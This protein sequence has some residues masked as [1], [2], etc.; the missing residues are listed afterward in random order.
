M[1]KI[2]VFTTHA[3]L[4]IE[5]AQLCIQQLS[6]SDNPETFDDFLVYNTHPNEL[7]N[8]T[9]LQILEEHKIQD[10]IAKNIK[11]ISSEDI[12]SRSLGS[13]LINIFT[14]C[15]ANYESTDRI[16]LLKSDCMVSCNLLSDLSKVEDEHFI[17]TP[18]F[19]TAK[20]RVKDDEITEYCSRPTYILSDDITFF[21]EDENNTPG[22]NDYSKGK[23][24]MD[25]QILFIACTGKS[26][27]SCH[28][29]TVE[30]SRS[31]S[32]NCQSW[33]GVNFQYLRKYWKQPENGF[34]VHKYHG[35]ISKNRNADR[36][37]CDYF[38]EGL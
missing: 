38:L 11:I 21:M 23:S 26:D 5:H 25:H 6:R 20:A 22:N 36:I 3:T 33:G 2:I 29:L 1:K 10:T 8:E 4:N 24:P 16:L 15:Q 12:N 30:L 28:Y 32:I 27:Y 13:D 35:V 34:V 9:I 37:G 18:P 14:Y 19:I 31:V 7:P 17:L